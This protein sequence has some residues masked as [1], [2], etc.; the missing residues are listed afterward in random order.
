MHCR[1]KNM[2]KK[3]LAILLISFLAIALTIGCGGGGDLWSPSKAVLK[4]RTVGVASTLPLGG[5]QVTLQMPAGVSVQTMPNSTQTGTNVIVAS[6]TATPADLV[7]GVYSAGTVSFAIIK[8]AGFSVGEFAT[9]NCD[10]AGDVVPSV[11]SF[12]VLY[13]AVSDSAGNLI[14]GL[15][16]SIDVS[17]K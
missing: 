9:V 8:V 15:T 10:L 13:Q 14:T 5:A 11:S 7:F 3:A 2:N 12:S 6:G 16:T 17:F 4:I 1:R